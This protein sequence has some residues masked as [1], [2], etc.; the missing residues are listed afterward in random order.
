MKKEKNSQLTSKSATTLSK[1]KNPH[2]KQAIFSGKQENSRTEKY[3]K[4][5]IIFP[6]VK[7]VCVLVHY[8]NHQKEKLL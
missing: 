2:Q 1:N 8:N 4:S 3:I 5:D 7:L 6:K